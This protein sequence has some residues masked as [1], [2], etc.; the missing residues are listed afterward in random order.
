MITQELIDKINELA[1]KKKENTITEK[2]LILQ[3][4]LRQEYLS[5]FRNNM[6]SVMQKVQVVDEFTIAIDR[7]DQ[8]T[9]DKLMQIDS[10]VQIQ[11]VDTNYK[12]VYDSKKIS[13]L[14]IKSLIH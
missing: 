12:I 9:L 7:V 2:E 8:L 13:E 5:L 3:K 1:K 14:D 10:I 4:E 11:K 6:N